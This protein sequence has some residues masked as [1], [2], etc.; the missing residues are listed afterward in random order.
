[1]IVWVFTTLTPKSFKVFSQSA[2]V[3]IG[4][5]Q[6]LLEARIGVMVVSLVIRVEQ[7]HSINGERPVP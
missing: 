7:G 3:D 4:A 6:T 5:A 2:A 1:M